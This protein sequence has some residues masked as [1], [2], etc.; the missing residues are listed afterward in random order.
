MTGWFRRGRGLYVCNEFISNGPLD[1]HI[2]TSSGQSV[3]EWPIRYQIIR[4]ICAGLQYLHQ[5]RHA[6]IL[7]MDLKPSNILLDEEMV[8]KIADFGLSRAFLN[9]KTHTYTK[10]VIGSK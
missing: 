7:H 8:P 3:I 1:K 5:D 2:F 10:E 9:T 4:G 6:N